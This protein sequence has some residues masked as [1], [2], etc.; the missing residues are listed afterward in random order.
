MEHSANVS[1][2]FDNRKN[3]HKGWKAEWAL[4]SE[5]FNQWLL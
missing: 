2:Y 1:G 4:D 5:V 3:P